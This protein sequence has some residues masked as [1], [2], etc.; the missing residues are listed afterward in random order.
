MNKKLFPLILIVLISAIY[1]CKNPQ[2]PE[3]K[4]VPDIKKNILEGTTWRHSD[5]VNSIDIVLNF[6]SSKDVEQ[7]QPGL[8]IEPAKGTYKLTGNHIVL[9]FG[10]LLNERYRGFLNGSEMEITS[11][12]GSD[13]KKYFKVKH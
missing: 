5:K 13:K 9:K 7:S 10:K 4:E 8:P 11:A 2:A 6:T 1:S 3:K 12:D